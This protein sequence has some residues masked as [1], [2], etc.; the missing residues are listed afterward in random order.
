MQRIIPVLHIGSFLT[1]D[2]TI[3]V[4]VRRQSPEIAKTS[5]L[6]LLRVRNC[7]RIP[8]YFREQRTGLRGR[9]ILSKRPEGSRTQI[10]ISYHAFP[11]AFFFRFFLRLVIFSST[12][13]IFIPCFVET[14]A[15]ITIITR[16]LAI[17]QPKWKHPS[18][19]P[20]IGSR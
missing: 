11:E 5:V 6:T 1:H 4:T 15:Q 18:G 7:Q 14:T 12:F 2:Y 10:L 13:M 19:A 9:R 8:V 16:T 20:N 3:P 17:Y